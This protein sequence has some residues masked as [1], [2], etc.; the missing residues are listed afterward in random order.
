VK[1]PENLVDKHVLLLDATLATGAAAKMAVRV[2]LDHGAR[3]E[4]IY[5]LTLI[6]S[7]QSLQSLLYTYPNVKIIVSQVDRG[8][9][10]QKFLKPGVG[11]FGNRYYGTE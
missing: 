9:S 5:F 1:L 6:A 8:L 7:P 2:L 10:E 11:N 3:E 4:N